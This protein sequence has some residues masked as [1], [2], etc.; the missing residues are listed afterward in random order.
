MFGSSTSS[1]PDVR[2]VPRHIA[3]I[4][5]G[6]GRWAKK[7]FLPRV[8]GHK[9]G[10]SAVREVVAGCQELGV[11]YLTLFAFSTEN[12]RRPQDE[13]S[14]LMDLFLSALENEVE[15]LHS[16][17]IR[18]KVIGDRSRFAPRIVER[19]TAAES[20]TATNDGLVL[21]IAADY[22]GRWDMLQAVNQLIGEGAGVITEEALAD[23]LSMA[24]APEPDLFIRTGGEQRIS[25]FLL[26]QLAYSELYFTDLLWPDFDKGALAEAVQSYRCRERRFGRTSEQLPASMRRD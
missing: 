3:I 19:I 8:A 13:V 4:M 25:N 7:R 1:I 9:K 17:N 15:K 23:R 21:T 24:Y 20:R 16:S 14:F 10:L 22:G 18:L 26:W 2:P 12:W 5:D 6:N 11:E